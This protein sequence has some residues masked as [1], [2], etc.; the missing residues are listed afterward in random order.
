MCH[1]VAARILL[2]DQLLLQVYRITGHCVP[3]SQEKTT[4]FV[5]ISYFYA[6]FNLSAFATLAF[7]HV[8]H[9]SATAML[10]FTQLNGKTSIV[11]F[12]PS[13]CTAY[14]R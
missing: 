5:P 9:H 1:G 6:H 7:L 2:C 8:F 10:C 14:S 13:Q 3:C 4:R 11:N 12:Q